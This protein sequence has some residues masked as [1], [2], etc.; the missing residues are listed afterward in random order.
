MTTSIE[1]LCE[2]IVMNGGSSKDIQSL[3]QDVKCTTPLL[4]KQYKSI[5]ELRE[6]LAKF[7]ER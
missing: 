2:A 5:Q 6:I 3:R 4:V 1:E 7:I